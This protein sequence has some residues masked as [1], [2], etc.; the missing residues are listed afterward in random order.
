MKNL[1]PAVTA[2]HEAILAD[3]TYQRDLYVD[4]ATS[5]RIDVV[6][7]QYGFHNLTHLRY[8][9]EQRTSA[10]IAYS[11]IPPILVQR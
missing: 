4:L 3:A 9:L 11:Y 1:G 2:V 6:A 8:V 7:Q 10:R 5:E